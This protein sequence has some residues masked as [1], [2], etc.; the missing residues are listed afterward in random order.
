M[1]TAF[2]TFF[3][4]YHYSF[5]VLLAFDLRQGCMVIRPWGMAVW[6]AFRDD[7]DKVRRCVSSLFFLHEHA[8]QMLRH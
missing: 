3:V 1:L 8:V 6:D 7:M 2:E 5:L 4:K